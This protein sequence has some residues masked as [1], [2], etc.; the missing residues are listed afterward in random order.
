MSGLA[1]RIANSATP[2]LAATSAIVGPFG[3][4]VTVAPLG[5]GASEARCAIA[6]LLDRIA[7]SVTWCLRARS[8]MVGVAGGGGL[9]PVGNLRA[10]CGGSG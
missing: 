10:V 9:L 1:C 5:S 7:S 4:I 2:F 8:P 6:G 3:G